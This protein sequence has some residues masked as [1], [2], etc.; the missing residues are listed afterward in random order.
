MACEGRR[1]LRRTMYDGTRGA[2]AGAHVGPLRQVPDL[3]FSQ[4]EFAPYFLLPWHMVQTRNCLGAKH[5]T[6]RNTKACAVA[7]NRS[8]YQWQRSTAYG[9]L[10]ALIQRTFLSHGIAVHMQRHTG[11][12]VGRHAAVVEH[13]F[14]ARV[15]DQG[16][17]GTGTE[18]SGHVF[19][20]SAVCERLHHDLAV[21]T[22]WC[23][24]TQHNSTQYTMLQPGTIMISS[25]SKSGAV[26]VP[27]LFSR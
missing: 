11:T 20:V 27:N 5:T 1:H 2:H 6:E 7:R 4:M 15:R 12:R 23:D 9:V 3:V 13:R 10:H 26:S 21:F 18:V 8:A 22:V 17:P 14:E 19:H 16:V 24:T 25:Y